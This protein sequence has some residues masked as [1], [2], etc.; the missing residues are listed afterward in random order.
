MIRG[1][2]AV[3]LCGIAVDHGTRVLAPNDFIDTADD[4]WEEDVMDACRQH[5]GHNAHT[6]KRLKHELMNRFTKFGGATACEIYGYIKP[7]GSRT[8]DEWKKDP[9]ATPIYEEWKRRLLG[10]RNCSAVADWLNQQ[11]VPTGKYA[12]RK[13]WDG[14]MVR[15]IT[16]NPLLKGMPSRGLK[17]TVKHHE[18]GRRVSVKNPNGPSF[19]ECPHLAFWT[20]AEF[21]E[22]NALLDRSNQHFKRKWV[23]GTDPLLHVPRKRT[24]IPGQ[25]ARCWY[26]GRQ[27]VWGGQR[28]DGKLDVLRQP[29][30]ALLEFH[31]IQWCL[32]CAADRRCGYARIDSAPRLRRPVSC[33]S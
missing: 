33:V 25:H 26:C 2:H 16:A 21:D 17:H 28:S 6:S 4:N 22:L 19:Y 32:S 29:R 7:P 12:R 30:V 14:P 5:V 13:S 9:A 27:Y 1:S 20:V 11:G 23:N 10:S 24:R 15:R 18:T 31:R 8:Y 3:L